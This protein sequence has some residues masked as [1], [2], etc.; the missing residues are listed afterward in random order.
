MAFPPLVPP[1]PPLTARER[2]RHARH[3]LLPGVGELGQRRLAAARVLLV[4]AGGLGSPAALYLAAAGVGTLG[5]VDDDVVDLTNLQRQILHRPQDV[6]RAK[7]ESGADGVHR[8]N[9]DT[10]VVTHSVRLTPENVLSVL[11]DYDVVVDGAD[12][13]PTRSLVSDACARLG[14]PHVWA[15]VHRF[16]AQ[17]SVWWAGQGPCYHCVFPTMPAPDQVPSCAVGGVLGATVGTIGSVLAVEVVKVVTGVGE[18]LV[19]RLLVHDGLAQTWDT[20]PVRPA[21][22]CPVCSSSAD[23]LRPLGSMPRMATPQSSQGLAA[24]ASGETASGEA[25]SGVAG[26]GEAS[27]PTVTVRELATLLAHGARLIDVREP[28]E[29]EIVTIPGAEAVPMAD[30]IGGR[31]D[32]GPGPVHVHCKSGARSARVVDALRARGVDARDVQGGVL[33]WVADVDPT[34]PTY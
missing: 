15:S 16:D 1:G 26:S 28:G 24:S 8:V 21:P 10:E 27:R 3:L 17:V 14:L 7:V 34:L 30:L 29:R 2:T 33:A 20:L 5:L 23:P 12:N 22:D 25:A 6:G 11:A 13:F 32:P 18:P 19:G 9:E 31:V 4:G